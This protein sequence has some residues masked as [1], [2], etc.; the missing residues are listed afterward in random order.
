[1]PSYFHQ[2]IDPFRTK[3][4]ISFYVVKDFY[5]SFRNL[6]VV[7]F[8]SL[9]DHMPVC[10]DKNTIY[11]NNTFMAVYIITSKAMVVSPVDYVLNCYDFHWHSSYY[12]LG[13]IISF[14]CD[15]NSSLG[16]FT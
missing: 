15:T 1:M 6:N 16:L 11:N 9:F 5:K 4:V 14:H 12:M 2:I 3:Y 7:N 10:V 13:Y 8:M